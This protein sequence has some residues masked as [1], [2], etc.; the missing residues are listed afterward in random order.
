M[1]VIDEIALRE[2]LEE[3]LA[4]M[5]REELLAQASAVT[6][7]NSRLALSGPQTDDELHAWIRLELGIDIPR[8]AVCEGHC[9]PFDFLAAVYFARSLNAIAIANRGGSK[10]YMAALLHYL[11]CRFMPGVETC[12]VG[13]VEMQAKRAYIHVGKLLDHKASAGLVD[14]NRRTQS[15]TNWKNT[16][17][18]EILGGTVNAVN[19]PHPQLT[20]LDEVELMDPEVLSEAANMPKSGKTTGGVEIPAQMVITSTRKRAHGQMARIMKDVDGA[21]AKGHIPAYDPYCWCIFETAANVPNCRAANPD[22]E[23]PCECHLVV[24]GEW[25]AEDGQPAKPRTLEDVCGGKFARSK[26]FITYNDIIRDFRTIPRSVWE[27]QNECLRPSTE[28]LVLKELT[29]ERYGVRLWDPDPE[30]G[31][32]FTVWDPGGTHPHCVLWVQYLKRSAVATRLN[33]KTVTIPAGARVVFDEI[34]VTDVAASKLADRVLRRELA[35]KQKHRDFRIVLRVADPAAKG[36]RLEWLHHDPPMPTVFYGQKNVKEEIDHLR[37]DI[38]ANGL[39][40]MDVERCE[41]AWEEAGQWHYPPVRAGMIDDPEIPV[42]DFDH[43][44]DCLRYVNKVI[45]AVLRKQRQGTS[46]PVTDDKKYVIDEAM[47]RTGP[48]AQTH[49]AFARTEAWRG[50]LGMPA[51]HDR[52]TR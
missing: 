13:A 4:G 5:S 2:A 23:N 10:T 49:N 19:G 50:S 37:D 21:I 48:K 40:Y 14:P 47:E 52:R 33:G 38:V 7:M 1:T 32:I 35:W 34:Y 39:L 24:N 25:D 15:E 29:P 17:K 12:S 16:S 26:G 18:I 36:A 28:G 46:A 45:K 30:L 20:H 31:P 27:A 22:V 8:V 3:K 9:A 11:R 42:E 41:W 43:A 51:S 6:Q 44:M